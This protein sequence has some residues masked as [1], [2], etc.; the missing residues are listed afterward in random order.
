MAIKN[1]KPV[2]SSMRGLKTIDRSELHKGSPM[3]MLSSGLVK[4]S[5]GRNNTGRI[6][7]RHRSIGHKKIIS[8]C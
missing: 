6:T 5:A 4:S 2:T 3:K 1:Y 7:V 8:L